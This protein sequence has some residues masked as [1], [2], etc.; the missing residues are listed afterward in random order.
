MNL[1]DYWIEFVNLAES[2][3]SDPLKSVVRFVEGV[4]DPTVRSLMRIRLTEVSG[5]TLDAVK[6]LLV[7]ADGYERD[8]QMDAA[9]KK[10]E[11]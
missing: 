5:K 10:Q 6:N 3:D 9:R 1:R 4:Q 8:R 7:L 11:Q 2:C